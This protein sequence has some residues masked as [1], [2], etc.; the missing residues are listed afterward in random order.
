MFYLREIAKN[1]TTS[2]RYLF[3][4]LLKTKAYYLHLN[5][6]DFFTNF[7]FNSTSSSL[8]PSFL[9]IFK[10]FIF[11]IISYKVYSYLSFITAV[12]IATVLSIISRVFIAAF[13]AD[14]IVDFKKVFLTSLMIFIAALKVAFMSV[15]SPTIVIDY[16]VISSLFF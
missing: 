1:K 15:R 8:T 4:Y 13:W 7:T 10:L 16:I 5:F 2:V 3:K 14:F 11:T 6:R 12:S 9:S